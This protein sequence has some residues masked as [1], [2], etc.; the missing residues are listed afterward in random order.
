MKRNLLLTPGP[1]VVPPQLCEVLGRPIIHH[2][3]PQFQDI[4]K[5]T[6]EGLK[7]IF[8]TTQ[9]VYLLAGSGSAA[10]EAAVCNLLSPGEQALTVESGK[11]GERWTELCKAYGIPA[12]V[13]EIE[14]G[15]AVT[16]EHIAAELKKDPAIKAVF[17]TL[18]ETSTAVTPNI[19]AV[20][21]LLTCPW[22]SGMWMLS[23]P[24]PIKD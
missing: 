21:A 20:W 19:E 14:W 22:T 6:E 18:C 2:R 24:D 7:Y 13:L 15:T 3:T 17:I 23:C 10:M 4:L 1:T 9:D 5:E 12:H 16:A 11:F 8:Q